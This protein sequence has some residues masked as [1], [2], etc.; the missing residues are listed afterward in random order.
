MCVGVVLSAVA[1]HAQ[2]QSFLSLDTQLRYRSAGSGPPIVFLSGGPGFDVDYMSPV[3]QFFPAGYSKILF[4]QRGTGRSRAGEET[5]ARMTLRVAV[6]DLDALRTHLKQERLFL[7]GHSWGGMLAMTYAAAHP[8]RIDRLILI[9]S[10]GPTLE[11]GTW[12]NDNISSRLH[13]QDVEARAYW[14]SASKL[15][16]DPVKA[17]TGMVRA[18]L[19]AYFF[20]RAQALAFAAEVKDGS[21]HPEVNTLLS[22]DMQRAYDLRPGLRKLGRPVLIVQGHQDPIGD[23]TA[24]DIHALIARSRLAFIDKAGHFPW[25]ERP[26][27]FRRIIT[28]FLSGGSDSAGR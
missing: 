3:A 17:A 24:E 14:E 26:D 4:D 13:P 23:K 20:D 5:A 10:G 22:E 21:Y 28:A 12:F 2:D 25:I 15:G 18:I 8:E 9:G 27:E 11:F 16:V 7:V 6:D 1:A 19:P